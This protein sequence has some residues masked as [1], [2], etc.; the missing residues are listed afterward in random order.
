MGTFVVPRRIIAFQLLA[1]WI[2][3]VTISQPSL[4]NSASCSSRVLS[5]S[6]GGGGGASGVPS[7]PSGLASAGGDV[8]SGGSSTD[9]SS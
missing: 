5:E 3:P 2:G 9:G 1:V 6:G 7:V 4:R 8:L